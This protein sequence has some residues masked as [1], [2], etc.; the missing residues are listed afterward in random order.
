MSHKK[1]AKA[2]VIYLFKCC[3]NIYLLE[4]SNDLTLSKKQFIFEHQSDN[5][6]EDYLIGKVLGTG[7]LFN[8]LILVGAFGEVRLCTHR[9]TGTKRAVKII[10]KSFLKGKEEKR[11]LEEIEILKTM[12]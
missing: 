1:E 9:K 12:V 11:F 2:L 10:K 8:Y 7:K 5:I 3:I 4:Q 6:R